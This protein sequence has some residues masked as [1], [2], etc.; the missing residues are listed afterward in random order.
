MLLTRSWAGA[1]VTDPA[2]N[3]LL[4]DLAADGCYMERPPVYQ[5]VVAPVPLP[6]PR[7]A[8]K[9]GR[10]AKGWPHHRWQP[11]V[12]KDSDDVERIA[13][14]P[15]VAS[16]PEVL[17]RDHYRY[18]LAALMRSTGVEWPDPTPDLQDPSGAPLA[19]S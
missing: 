15:P 18:R 19:R 13:A 9:P 16:R 1:V 7:A 3:D 17:P 4:D 11:V 8:R 2:P 12:I 5:R 14:L 6:P 10:K